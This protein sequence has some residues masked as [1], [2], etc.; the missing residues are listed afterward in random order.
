M[1]V[2]S[3]IHY[4]HFRDQDNREF[5]IKGQGPFAEERNRFTDPSPA[6]EEGRDVLPRGLRIR[7]GR[8]AHILVYKLLGLLEP[9]SSR[10][11]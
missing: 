9:Y 4:S 8:F 10:I 3:D 7:T 5:S 1:R 2:W 6:M 11:Q